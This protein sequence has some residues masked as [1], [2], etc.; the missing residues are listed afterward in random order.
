MNGSTK[1]ASRCSN[2]PLRAASA[3]ALFFPRRSPSRPAPSAAGS[4]GTKLAATGVRFCIGD[5]LRRASADFDGV[6]DCTRYGAMGQ[7]GGLRGVRGEM[8]YLRDARRSSCARPVRLLHPRIPGLCRSARRR[9]LHGGRHD[10]RDANATGPITA[11]SMMELLNAAYALHPAFA[12]AGRGRNRRGHPPRLS[13]QLSPRRPR[14][15][16][17][18]A[19]NG[20]YRHGFLLAPAHGARGGRPCLFVS[21]STKQGRNA[22]ETDRQRRGPRT[23]QPTTLCRTAGADWNTRADWLATARQRRNRPPRATASTTRSTT[24]TGSKSCRRCR[25]ADHAR[26]STEPKCPP[27]CCSAR[28]ATLRRRFWRRP[29][30]NRNGNRHRLA[31]PRDRRRPAAAA[32]SSR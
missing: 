31:A 13:R 11:R 12:E 20:L 15:G 10:D 3:C 6:V 24:T 21:H 8:L 7:T 29:S 18:V 26:T 30:G 23:S 22:D 32:P 4:C 17:V 25:E 27:A 1:S 9:P 28:R 2:R 16:N 5:D 19:L 14:D